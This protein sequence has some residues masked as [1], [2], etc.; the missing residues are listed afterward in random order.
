MSLSNRLKYSKS[1]KTKTRSNC[2][3]IEHDK[4]I[5][6]ESNT[7]RTTD[8]RV[9]RALRVPQKLEKAVKDI[10]TEFSDA[11]LSN[12]YQRILY[13]GIALF[14]KN[15]KEFLDLAQ[16]GKDS[17]NSMHGVNYANAN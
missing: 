2:F 6:I 15:Q 3:F 13:A 4:N 1:R 8:V 17:T 10:Q 5:N 14:N 7:M 11:S 9:S 12:S 16:A